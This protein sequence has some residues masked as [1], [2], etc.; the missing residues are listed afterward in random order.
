MTTA[1]QT[2]T[3]FLLSRIAEDEAAAREAI[4]ISPADAHP[5]DGSWVAAPSVQGWHDLRAETPNQRTFIAQTQKAPAFAHIVRHDPARV[6]AECEA[7]RNVVRA[8]TFMLTTEAIDAEFDDAPVL[9]QS[10]L[11]TLASVFDDHPDFDPAWA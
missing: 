10:I 7:R 2:L 5:L 11:R 8:C 3:D 1:T 4:R 9:A 6:L